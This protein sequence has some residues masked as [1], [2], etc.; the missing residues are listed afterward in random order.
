MGDWEFSSYGSCLAG[1]AG[2]ES[3]YTSK[4]GGILHIPYRAEVS[5]RSPSAGPL[6]LKGCC[7]P[8]KAGPWQRGRVV[9]SEPPTNHSCRDHRAQQIKHFH[10]SVYLRQEV[11]GVGQNWPR[12]RRLVGGEVCRTR[13]TQK[14]TGVSA[15]FRNVSHCHRMNEG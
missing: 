15:A 1:E 8:L 10:H 7:L 13:H 4:Q 5:V 2:V 3:F 14:R 11:G 9:L 6:W 12:R